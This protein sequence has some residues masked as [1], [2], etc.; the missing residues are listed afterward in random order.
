MIIISDDKVETV[1]TPP[2]PQPLRRVR[3]QM[4]D[5]QMPGISAC[6]FAVLKISFGA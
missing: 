2:I 4:P 6:I 3:L 5:L 1:M